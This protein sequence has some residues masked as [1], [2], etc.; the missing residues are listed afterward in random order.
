MNSNL[1]DSKMLNQ[2]PSLIELTISLNLKTPSKLVLKN[3]DV[4]LVTTTY[5]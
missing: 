2:E 5:D 1:R 4:P 3:E